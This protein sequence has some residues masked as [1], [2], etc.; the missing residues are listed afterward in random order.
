[1]DEEKRRRLEACGWKVGTVA[2]FLELTP[3]EATLVERRMAQEAV[4]R[5]RQAAVTLGLDQL[6]SQEIEPEIAQTRWERKNK[7]GG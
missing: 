7:T 3:E 2:E 4:M 6:T 1:M 5:L